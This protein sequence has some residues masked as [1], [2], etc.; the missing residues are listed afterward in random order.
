MNG[1]YSSEYVEVQTVFESR[2]RFGSELCYLKWREDGMLLRGYLADRLVFEK[3]AVLKASAIIALLVEVSDL[4]VSL[5]DQM[6]WFNF[7]AVQYFKA[8]EFIAAMGFELDLENRELRYVSAGISECWMDTKE[9]KGRILVSGLFLGVNEKAYFDQ[10]CIKI[11]E[12]DSVYFLTDGLADRVKEKTTGYLAPFEEQVLLLQQ[13]ACG[14][15][16]KDDATAMCLH[17]RSLPHNHKT[18]FTRSE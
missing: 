10:G 18:E 11:A 7:R 1:P 13:L 17:I 4:S 3:S 16:K 8:K 6:C 15:A 5:M 2:P 14:K 12:G 9:I